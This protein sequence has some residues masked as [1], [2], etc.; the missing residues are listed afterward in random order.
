MRKWYKLDNVGTFY[1]FTKNN[2]MP[3]VF[4]YSAYIKDNIDEEILQKALDKTVSI[5]PNFNVNLKKG[6]YWYY[7][8]EAMRKNKVSKENL[9]I[10]YKLYE[11]SD[12]FL[13]RISYFKNKINME[14]SHILSDGRGSVEFFKLLI[15]NYVIIKYN[16]KAN[17]KIDNS[18]LE[19]SEDSFTKYYEK[20]K[21]FKKDKGKTY[22]YKGRKLKNQTRYME[23]HIPLNSVLDLSHKYNTTLTS[24]LVSILIYSFMDEVK[25][26]ELN[27]Y[28][29]VA[30]PVDLRNFFK[31]TTSMNFFGLTT[32]SYNFKNKEEKLENI[33]DNVNKQFKEKITK[34]SLRER[35]NLMVSFEKNWFCRLAPL[36]L[37][38]LTVNIADKITMNANTT[39][40]SNIGVIKLDK[41]IE[42]Y[43]NS[44]SVITSTDGFQFTICSFKDDLCIGISD[45]YVNNNIVKNFCRYFSKNNINV[46]M[47][48]SEVKK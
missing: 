48:V 21:K 30:L 39:C 15:T 5:F 25:T 37:K 18:L 3:K 16:V 23:Y 6:F 29:R 47:D 40:L 32:I 24:F 11:N 8:D 36:S 10:C 44:M 46:R 19:K 33:I 34:E 28:I 27:K 17:Y 20:T 43:I 4:R 12:D 38:N 41:K 9:P 45:N 13:Y 1:A 26:S 42:E 14:I 35:V 31:S 22:L 7:L 2:K